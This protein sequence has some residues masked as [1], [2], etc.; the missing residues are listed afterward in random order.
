MFAKTEN[1]IE[2]IAQIA[3]GVLIGNLLTAAF[4]WTVMSWTIRVAAEDAAAAL[5]ASVERVGREQRERAAQAQASLLASQRREAD[6]Q[7]AAE[8]AKRAQIERETA[9]ELAWKRFYQKPAHC[10]ESRGGSWTVDCANEFIRAKRDF[11]QRY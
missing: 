7:R 10:D 5:N 11:E 6:A 2:R 4:I 3:V 8:A 1:A 9:K